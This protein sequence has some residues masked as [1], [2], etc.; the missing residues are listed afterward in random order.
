MRATAII[1]SVFHP[2]LHIPPLHF[3]FFARPVVECESNISSSQ[4]VTVSR[5][6][7]MLL[8]RRNIG[9][10]M[11]ASVPGLLLLGFAAIHCAGYAEALLE[12]NARNVITSAYFA[13]LNEMK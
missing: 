2:C 3:F 12:V 6:V 5:L 1:D 13:A 4:A 11:K 9:K 7:L 8:T 10:D